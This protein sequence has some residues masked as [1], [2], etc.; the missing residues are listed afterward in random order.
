MRILVTGAQGQLG[1]ALQRVAPLNKTMEWH[2]H[3]REDLDLLDEEMVDRMVRFLQP[4]VIINTAAYTAVDQAEQEEDKAYQL[5]RDAV[6][7]LAR[8]AQHTG[9]KIIQ[10]STDYVYD[11]GQTT[12]YLETDQVRPGG[13]Y[14]HSKR[15]GEEA[16]IAI[17]PAHV[18]MRTSWL[19]GPVRH[20]FLQTMLR[21]GGEQT[22]LQV[23]YDQ[24]GTPT[25]TIDLSEA[26]VQI[27]KQMDQDP[28]T[29]EAFQ[30]IYNFS[31]EGV[32][33]WYDFAVAIMRGKHLPCMVQPVRS[34]AFPTPAQRPAYSVMDKSKIKDQFGLQIAHWQEALERCLVQTEG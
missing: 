34:A 29:G 28:A 14:A 15:A 2:F 32:C 7:Y 33:S 31:N 30:G 8:A 10:L 6:V 20:N 13:V 11:N 9:S 22:Q 17:D 3:G 5:N 16:L 4:E 1:L 19:Y 12:P 26:I 21:L 23:V 24:V 18:I 25:C 27:L